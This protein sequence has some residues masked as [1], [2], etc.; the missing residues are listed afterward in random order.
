MHL[1]SDILAQTV[2][3]PEQSSHN[4]D[5]KEQISLTLSEILSSEKPSTI[6]TMAAVPND[7][8]SNRK[9]HPQTEKKFQQYL[10]HHSLEFPIDSLALTNGFMKVCFIFNLSSDQYAVYCIHCSSASKIIVSI[11]HKFHIYKPIIRPHLARFQP[12]VLC[13]CIG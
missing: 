7:A 13:K 12:S 11:C 5:S 2:D 8:D 10:C 9:I 4:E 3:S 1:C 6:G